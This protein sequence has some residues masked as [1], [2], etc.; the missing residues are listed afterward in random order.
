ML[1]TVAVFLKEH[2]WVQVDVEG[3]G[4][5]REAAALSEAR[6]RNVTTFLV[7]HGVD[8]ARIHPKGY[9]ATK[10]RAPESTADGRAENRRVEF[11]V[12]E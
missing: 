7:R 5:A 11:V 6:A 3:Y 2:T 4:D 12:N 10:P 8:A 1:E 9:G